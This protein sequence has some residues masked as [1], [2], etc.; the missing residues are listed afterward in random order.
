MPQNRNFQRVELDLSQIPD[1]VFIPG[2]MV[3]EVLRVRPLT[4]AE[5]EQNP[6]G[7]PDILVSPLVGKPYQAKRDFIKNNYT[8]VNGRKVNI[9]GWKSSKLY[10]VVRPS[11]IMVLLMQVPLNHTVNANGVIA[12]SKSRNSGDYIVCLPDEGGSL[13]RTTASVVPAQLFHKICYIQPHPSIEKAARGQRRNKLFD[14]VSKC[15]P[16]VTKPRNNSRRTPVQPNERRRNSGVVVEA[17]IL[18]PN[19]GR[20]QQNQPRVAPQPQN[21]V[22]RPMQTAPGSQM[23]QDKFM[24]VQNVL[25]SYGQRVGFVIQAS[26]GATRNINRDTATQLCLQHKI[27]NMTAV[28]NGSG[29]YFFRGIG[30]SLDSLPTTYI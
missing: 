7:G 16:G 17:D 18:R 12:N 22:R 15:I 11:D 26:N 13:D 21:T 28:D 3:R 14:M 9:H 20:I 30:I 27:A 25:N 6:R 10:V 8:Y 24:V 23:Q 19:S 1:K 5:K 29:E 4:Q 2:V